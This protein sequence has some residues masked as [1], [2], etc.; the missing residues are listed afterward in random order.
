MADLHAKGA[1]PH[2]SW[3]K[4]LPEGEV[5]ILGRAPRQGL[6][7]PWDMMISREHAELCWKNGQL[8]VKCLQTARNPIYLNRQPTPEFAI[9][10]GETFQ[11][12]DTQFRLSAPVEIAS[13]DVELLEEQVFGSVELQQ[14][15]F[16]DP[17]RQLGLTARIPKLLANSKTDEDF[18]H[19]LASLLLEALPNSKVVAVICDSEMNCLKSGPPTMMRWDS[20]NSFADRFQPSR[21]MIASALTKAR[22]VLQIWSGSGS[23]FNAKFTRFSNLDW[24]ICTPITNEACRGWCLYIS[25]ESEDDIT[26]DDLKSDLK[27]IDMMAEFIGATRQVR[28]LEKMQANMSQFF[29]ANVLETLTAESAQQLLQPSERDITV[30][31]CDVR[32][33]SKMTERSNSGLLL[34]L[35]RVTDALGL[36]T[37][38]IVKYDGIISD[39]QGDAALGFWGWPVSLND[40]PIPA[41]QAALAIQK[42]FAE[43]TLKP[44]HPL[45]DFRVG[46]GV[47]HGR[48]IAGRIGSMEQAKIG[49]FGPP[50]N[51]GSRLE[52]LTKQFQVRILVD[53]PTADTIRA[54]VSRTEARV[55]K[56]GRVRPAGMETSLVISEL[57][58]GLAAEGILSDEQIETFES[59]VES[60]RTGDW[61][62]AFVLLR[63]MPETDGP[64][65]FL[66]RF[67]GHYQNL[68]P[69]DWDGVIPLSQ[70]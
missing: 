19:K 61:Q 46:I 70:K 16:A 56:I 22:S 60:L 49:V 42:S 62:R 26:A 41:C 51:L 65:Q 9:R 39:F 66:L 38:A 58:P 55:R 54:S 4:P 2:E 10:D 27:L 29:S 15:P 50:V 23:A 5:V 28:Q 12:G 14:I 1:G 3:Q 64:S 53:E 59:A 17:D 30:L 35:S 40:G 67:M 57:L 21:K 45:K 36:M 32:G 11:I 7:V 18:A 48:A 13:S 20:R 52:G 63:K 6:R 8:V 33:F 31:F 68:P 43:A 34:L 44:N 25:G 37:Q 47:A 24:A 69:A